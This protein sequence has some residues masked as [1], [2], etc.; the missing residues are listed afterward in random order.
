MTLKWLDE[1]EI[2]SGFMLKGKLD[3]NAVNP[4]DL[5]PPYH[6]VVPILRDGGSVEDVVSKCGFSIVR[7]ALAAADAVNGEVP[8]LGWLKM[9]EQSASRYKSGMDFERIGKDLQAGKD[10][11]LGK[12]LQY[13]SQVNLGYRALTPLSEVVPAEGIWLKTGYKPLDDEVGGVPEAGLTIIAGSPGIGKTSLML[14]ILVSMIRRTKKKK[15]A[16]FSLEMLL[17]Q[18][19]K[20]ILDIDKT[21]TKEDRSRILASETSYTI[22]EVYALAAK[23]AA[24]ENLA[25]IGIDF[26]DLLVEGEQTE[27]VMGAI[28]RS[29]SVLAKQTKVPVILVSQLNRSTYMGGLPKINHIRYSSM[30]EMMAS[31]ILLLYNP[32]TI[33][34]DFKSDNTLLP[35]EG[36]GYILEGKSRFGFKK[37]SPIAIKVEWDGRDGWG[38]KS[39]GTFNITM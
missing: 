32:N 11:E 10:V 1:T 34:A 27:A 28:Y 26:A 12:I 35:E 21:L 17:S 36:R 14:K 16:L 37:G 4:A 8:P 38:D 3:P 7:D 19:T 33:M 31:L 15:V 25:A 18:V 24:T 30:A 2:V 29:L 22:G 20:R 5:Y 23:A 6:E 9:L 39:L 13:T